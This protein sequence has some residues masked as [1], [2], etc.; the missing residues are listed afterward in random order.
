MNLYIFKSRK[1]FLY[2]LPKFIRISCFNFSCSSSPKIV[3]QKWIA[4]KIKAL[5]RGGAEVAIEAEVNE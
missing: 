3:K 4:N 5:Y 2:L 1:F